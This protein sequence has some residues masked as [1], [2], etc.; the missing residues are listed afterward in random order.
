MP[1]YIYFESS[2][3][4]DINER[5]NNGLIAGGTICSNLVKIDF[6]YG[7]Y[8][9]LGVDFKSNSIPQNRIIKSDLH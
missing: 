6:N 9:I 3:G 7:S 2:V 5:S 8:T 4:L 1:S